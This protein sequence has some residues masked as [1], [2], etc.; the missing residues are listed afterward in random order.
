VRAH[1]PGYG[2]D[3]TDTAKEA[4]VPE[5]HPASNS[6]ARKRHEE[7]KAANTGGRDLS[8]ELLGTVRKAISD[9]YYDA[10][11]N[12]QTMEAAADAAVAALKPILASVDENAH[13]RGAHEAKAG[14]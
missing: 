1:Q 13:R 9:A 8:P 10:R 14:A 3:P 5:Q 6:D 12:G 2:P 4:N 11:N 7:A